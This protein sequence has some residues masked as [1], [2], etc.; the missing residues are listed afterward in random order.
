MYTGGRGSIS[1]D[2]GDGIK[3]VNNGVVWCGSRDGEIVMMEVDCV[4]D[5]EGLCFGIDDVMPAVVLNLDA[6]IETIRATEVPGVAGGWFI[7]DDD[8]AAKG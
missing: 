2:I 5:V 7:L 8:R 1:D 3:V 4:E 6:N